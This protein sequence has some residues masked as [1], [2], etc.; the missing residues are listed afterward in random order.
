MLLENCNEWET[1]YH[2]FDQIDNLLK[3]MST[4]LKRELLS[5]LRPK[6]GRS[7]GL[8]LQ[9]ILAF[10]IF[11]FATGV[12]DIKHYHRKLLSSYSK[13][14]GRIPN[15]GNFNN[16]M[17]QATPY[18]IFLLQWIC[19]F[20]KAKQDGLTFMD[21]TPLKVCENKRIFDHK[22]CEDVAQ[23]GKTST[24]WFF[25]FKLH[26][27]CDSLGRLMS[28]L[29]TPGNTDD[30]KFV[31]KLLKGLKGL[32]IADAGYVS[33]TLMQTLYQ[34]GLLL[35]TDVRNSMKRLMTQTQHKL[36]KL[37]QPIEGIFSCLKHRLKAE[38]SGARS[39]LGYLSR[40]LYACLTF[41]LSNELE[42]N[43]LLP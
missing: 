14:L 42:I 41:A 22:V 12:K 26:V 9:A 10:G 1:L 8:S 27:V 25:G 21:S 34:Q 23:R 19:Y 3:A 39:P 2:I 35:L 6:G 28:L 18:V 31:L 7:S 37:R 40:C 4:S 29:I 38:A 24:G 13:E 5:N 43:A 33:K 30:R 20:N 16:L 11:R 32:C 15:Y 17:N 36:L